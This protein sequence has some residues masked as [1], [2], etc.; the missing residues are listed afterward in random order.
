MQGMHVIK[1]REATTEQIEHKQSL[2]QIVHA[3]LKPKQSTH[4]LSRQ[5]LLTVTLKS[6]AG[7]NP[8]QAGQRDM[9]NMST[10]PKR[11]KKV[12]QHSFPDNSHN[13]LA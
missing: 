10:F 9:H 7:V 8:W 6:A 1:A 5:C 11:D 3:C 4:L 12:L 13:S 2:L